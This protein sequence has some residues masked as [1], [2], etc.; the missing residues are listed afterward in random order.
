MD[1]DS[2]HLVSLTL[3]DEIHNLYQDVIVVS[4]IHMGQRQLKK[5]KTLE[6]AMQSPIAVPKRMPHIAPVFRLS[7]AQASKPIRRKATRH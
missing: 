4:N 7:I 2:Y 6:Y 5:M 1:N 3:F